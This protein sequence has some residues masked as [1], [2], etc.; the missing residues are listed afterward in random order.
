MITRV[1]RNNF[2]I[3][4]AVGL[5]AIIC[6]SGTAFATGYFAGDISYKKAD[7]TQINVETALNELY[8]KDI[9][10]RSLMVNDTNRD[11][12]DIP[13]GVKEI[14]VF[15]SRGTT[16]I[17]YT[18]TIS[19]TEIL[20]NELVSNTSRVDVN[21][22]VYIDIYKITLTG[23]SGKITLSRSGGN[24]ASQAWNSCIVY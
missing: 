2:K 5:T 17:P 14:Y 16:N 20:N 18:I 21:M 23:N 13:E 15:V 6:I 19:G 7:G 4:L 11:E 1:I 22:A 8:S 24:A 3:I 10:K 12:Y 9:N